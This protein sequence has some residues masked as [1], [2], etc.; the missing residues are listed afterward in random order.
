MKREGIIFQGL[1]VRNKIRKA[2]DREQM[3]PDLVREECGYMVSGKEEIYDRRVAE[4]ME[5]L[6][7]NDGTEI[8][9]DVTCFL[10]FAMCQNKICCREIDAMSKKERRDYQRKY[11]D[12]VL[13]REYFWSCLGYEEKYYG[14]ILLGMLET[15]RFA[16]DTQATK[17]MEKFYSMVKKGW[18]G[19]RKELLSERHLKFEKI[20]RWVR[21]YTEQPAM[22]MSQICMILLLA[23]KMQILVE[24]NVDYYLIMICLIDRNSIWHCRKEEILQMDEEIPEEIRDLAIEEKIRTSMYDVY[25]VQTGFCPENY[26]EF[27]YFIQN[28]YHMG[29][30]DRNVLSGQVL[31]EENRIRLLRLGDFTKESCVKEYVYCLNIILLAQYLCHCLNKIEE[32][33]SL[34]LE[35]RIEDLE[36]ENMGLKRE[37][38]DLKTRYKA[39]E[40]KKEELEKMADQLG[41]NL[42]KKEREMERTLQKQKEEKEEL[43]RLR[44]ETYKNKID[45]QKKLSYN[46]VI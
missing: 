5:V 43:V 42:R 8:R 4:V 30:I 10:I 35:N 44:E 15:I 27:D 16:E 23:E 45:K 24:E 26:K 22:G 9:I 18:H 34:V 25:R 36:Q 11:K 29:G 13:F 21:E 2:M 39:M 37:L 38:L 31:G 19:A 20:Q 6:M 17:T 14:G 46:L 7:E 1:K 12:R 33:N 40:R 32:E 3:N 41:K 28:L